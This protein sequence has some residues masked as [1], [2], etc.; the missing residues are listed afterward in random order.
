MFTRVFSHEINHINNNLRQRL[1]QMNPILRSL[2]SED[3]LKNIVDKKNPFISLESMNEDIKVLNSYIKIMTSNSVKDKRK[4]NDINIRKYFADFEK[5]WSHIL[6]YRDITLNIKTD[7]F[8]FRCFDFDLFSIVANLIINSSEAFIEEEFNGQRNIIMEALNND[9]I[10]TL[11]Y[12]DTGP[13]L[14]ERIKN[15]YDIFQESFSTKKE[16]TG[17]GMWILQTLVN[18]YQGEVILTDRRCGFNLRINFPK[19]VKTIG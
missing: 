4:R 17:I 5:N 19:G 8:K 1:K 11:N 2:I 9:G 12:S 3:T 13:G 18:E 7:N 14:D 16:G 6:N 15:P 10:F